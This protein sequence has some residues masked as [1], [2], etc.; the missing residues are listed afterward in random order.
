M[1]PSFP[2]A[3][4]NVVL[5]P[6]VRKDEDSEWFQDVWLAQYNIEASSSSEEDGSS[7]SGHISPRVLSFV[8]DLTI[9]NQ[10]RFTQAALNMKMTSI[11]RMAWK[12]TLSHILHHLRTIFQKENSL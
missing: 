9:Q 3:V 6:L 1:V 2:S 8:H 7:Y 10:D 5:Y 4:F 11:H 12:I